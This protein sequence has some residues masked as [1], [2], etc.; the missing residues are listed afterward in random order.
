MIN[1]LNIVLDVIEDINSKIILD[2]DLDLYLD[3]DLDLDLYLYL[4]F[5]VNYFQLI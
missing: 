3:L 5:D 2:L 4:Y 1:Q